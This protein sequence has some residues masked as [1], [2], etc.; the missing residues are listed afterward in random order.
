MDTEN[1]GRILKEFENKASLKQA[2]YR[3]T[4]EIFE[5]LKKQLSKTAGRLKHDYGVKDTSV[6]IDY[7]ENNKFEAQLKFSGD[8]L[9]VSM[10]SNIFNFEP[11]HS[12]FK[13]K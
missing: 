3:N 12:I 1:Y 7:K 6:E 10:H 2:I 5:L 8:M 11:A 4:T 13:T 9:M